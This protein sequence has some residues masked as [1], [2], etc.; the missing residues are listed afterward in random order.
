MSSIYFTPDDMCTTQK[1]KVKRISDYFIANKWSVV[2]D[3]EAADI[4][5]CLTCS[6]W[7]KLE[8]ISLD[9]LRALQYLGNKVVSVGCVNDVNPRAVAEIH[10]GR[11]ISMQRLKDIEDLIPDHEVRLSDI[12][13][14]STFRCKEDYRLYDL[15][16]RFVNIASGCSFSCS[17]CPHKIGLGPL[18]SR[19]VEDI[20]A[21]V[22]DL[23]A[24]NVRIVVLT[25]METAFYGRDIGTNYP[26][27]IRK[28]ME[29]DPG[30]EIHVAQFN[31]A[32]VLK[33]CDELLPLF[34]STRVTDIQIP[35]Q[36]TSSR[37]LRLMNRPLKVDK[38][39]RFLKEIRKN[40]KKAV[41][42]TDIIVGFPTETIEELNETLRFV[43]DVYDEVAVYAFELRKGLPVERLTDYVLPEAEMAARVE[44]AVDFVEK[45]GRMAHG[46]QQSGVSLTEVEE[47]KEIVRRKRQSIV[48]SR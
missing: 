27:L 7:E 28:V 41:F 13:E 44:Y 47:R 4:V 18:R 40:N 32:G 16:K 6:G 19:T 33:Y 43:T 12:P 34:S 22:E 3:P 29:V 35:L 39:N 23:V 26:Y 42:R 2:T 21:Q 46:G 11:C 5:L 17:Y 20:T 24:E 8:T 48:N 1:L 45:S 15:T 31:P 38:V 30:F 36:T 9:R 14:P 37:I 25:G 10:H